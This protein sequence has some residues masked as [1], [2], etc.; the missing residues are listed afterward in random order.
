M[1]YENMVN[2]IMDL[3][4]NE[5]SDW[6]YNFMLDMQSKSSFTPAQ[7]G[8]IKEIHSKYMKARRYL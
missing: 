2:S 5:L 3:K 7:Q 8:K 1:N 4:E 6:E